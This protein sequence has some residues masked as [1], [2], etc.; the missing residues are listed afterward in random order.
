MIFNVTCFVNLY[1]ANTLRKIIYGCG[2]I[3]HEIT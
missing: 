1:G 3:S 2:I